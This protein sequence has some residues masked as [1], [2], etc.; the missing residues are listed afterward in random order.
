MLVL[1][2]ATVRFVP[3][4]FLT[5]EQAEAY[6]TFTE[7]PTR[8]ELERFFFLDD[9]DRDLIALRRTDAH[10]LSMAVQVCT[11][12]HAGRFLADGPLAVQWEVVEHLAEQLGIGDASCVKRCPERRGAPYEHAQEIR[13]RFGYRDF[14]D[15][16]PPSA[17]SSMPW[18][19][20]TGAP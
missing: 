8:P 11:V 6:G 20:G 3:V 18:C 1:V 19:C 12:R 5:G 4:E 13:E 14:S 15:R 16:S 7:V 10:R 9:D 2:L 17:R